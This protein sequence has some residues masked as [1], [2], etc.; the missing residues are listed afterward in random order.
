MAVLMKC[1]QAANEVD[2]EERQL[3]AVQSGAGWCPKEKGGRFIAV[4]ILQK[5]CGR[6]SVRKKY[7]CPERRRDERVSR[8]FYQKA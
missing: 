7:R 6:C 8:R 2:S 3:E 1:G 5:R 4:E